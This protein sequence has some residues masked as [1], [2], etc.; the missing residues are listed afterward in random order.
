MPNSRSTSV[1]VKAAVGSSMTITR[2]FAVSAFAISTSCWSAIERPRASRSGSSRTPSCANTAA[3]SRRMRLPSMR[4]KR[5]SGCIPTKMFSATLRSG[6]RIGSW[7]MIAI[8]AACDCFALSK[9]ASSPSRTRRPASGRWTPARIFTSVD[10]PAPFSPTRPCTSPAK[11][12]MSPSSRACTAPKLF[13]ACS[14][15]STGSGSVVV[16]WSWYGDAAEAASP[17]SRSFLEVELVH[18]LDRERERRPEDHLRLPVRGL[19]DPVRTELAGLERLADLAGDLAFRERAHRVARQ[20]S[21]VFGVPERER[22][23]RAVVDVLLH[24]ARQAEARE[25]DLLLVLRG[26][27]VLRRRRDPD[28]RG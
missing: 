26:G 19:D 7:K 28:G 17:S 25:N 2:A 13:S 23:H 14:R 20:V 18:V 11:S 5:L 10:L 24:L 6:K 16:T 4:R 27:E 3:A 22:R 12:A 8:P 1:V 21:Q 15:T 9:I